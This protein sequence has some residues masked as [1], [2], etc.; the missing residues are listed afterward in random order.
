MKRRRQREHLMPAVPETALPPAQPLD[1]DTLAAL[2]A[3]IAA[4]SPAYRAAVILCEL[5][6]VPRKQAAEELG[7]PE[8]TLSSRLAAARK[9]LA[10]RLRQRGITLSVGVAALLAQSG[11]TTVSASLQVAAV[12]TVMSGSVSQNIALLVSGVLRASSTKALLLVMSGIT[13]LSLGLAMVTT[14]ASVPTVTE[15]PQPHVVAPVLPPVR[16]D[17]EGDPLP[18]GA[19]ARLGTI[20]FHSCL[21]P[22]FLTASPDGT[23]FVTYTLAWADGDN[24]LTIWDTA[25]GRPLRRIAVPEVE[26]Q[27][28]TWL[29]DGRSFAVVKVNLDD[30]ALWEFTD[31]NNPHP[32][33]VRRDMIHALGNGTFR[34]SAIA[35]TGHLVA[36]GQQAGKAGNEGRVEV[37]SLIPN[38]RVRQMQV[39]LRQDTP[40]VILGLAFS[41]D[42]RRLLALT[43]RMGP[44]RMGPS[45]A[46]GAVQVLPGEV[47]DTMTVYVWEVATWREAAHFDIPAGLPGTLA[48]APDG[49]HLYLAYKPGRI[50]AYN[51]GDGHPAPLADLSRLTADKDERGQAITALKVAPDGRT[52]LAT[53]VHTNVVA[54]DSQ[55]GNI[56]W[57]SLYAEGLPSQETGIELDEENPAISSL[58]VLPD[59]KRFL[60]GRVDGALLVGDLATGKLLNRQ[61]GSQGMC[62]AVAAEPAGDT[63]LTAATDHTI[64]R[65]DLR[66]GR[67]LGRTALKGLAGVASCSISPDRAVALGRV[68]DGKGP[69]VALLDLITGKPLVRLDVPADYWSRQGM[70][71]GQP[72]AWLPD[73]SVVLTAGP[74]KAIRF[75]R[76]GKPLQTYVVP[77][78]PPGGR[79]LTLVAA[80]P[81]GKTLV[82]AG[83]GRLGGLKREPSWVSVYDLA[84]GTRRNLWETPMEI[85]RAEFPPNRSAVLLT[86]QVSPPTRRQD[87]APIVLFDL[88]S[89]TGTMPYRAAP[90][91]GDLSP[92]KSPGRAGT[93]L[94]VAPDGTE[95][96]VAWFD[97]SITVY[98]ISTG[99]LR[100]QFRGHDSV[101]GQLAY[102]PDTRRLISVSWDGTGL[103]W[104]LSKP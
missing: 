100:R 81:D 29:A 74:D 93:A 71:P 50:V 73:G 35:P 66:T 53:L 90:D 14:A 37:W 97:G 11:Q 16:K 12:Q 52:L 86:G 31:P 2:D 55:T 56:C 65:W 64:R 6:G 28:A 82:L 103:V 21:Q 9:I 91:A 34:A 15:N 69:G 10:A 42:G 99:V 36:G 61:A 89:G 17:V 26:V 32:A 60:V 45:F 46:G 98:E 40:G 41:S 7:I 5:R 13:A 62:V 76:Y 77:S 80:A 22:H 3:E 43:Q 59:S 20:R 54:L 85:L 84:S 49:R 19:L 70:L 104:D 30:Y 39:Q 94:A 51:L 58:T 18:P 24:V 95:F 78:D 63:A 8:G 101:I 4:L 47:A 57:H 72:Q 23:K 102:T 83:R 48:V 87:P 96:A 75:N 44:P 92:D 38:G 68:R 88:V 1:A 25:S 67:E 33:P 27:S 79:E